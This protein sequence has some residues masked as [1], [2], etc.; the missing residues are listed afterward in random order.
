MIDREKKFGEGLLQ[1]SEG[2]A[3]QIIQESLEEGKNIEIPSQEIT[4]RG[5]QVD[6]VKEDD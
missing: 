5:W 2:L 4:V 3:A 6:Q 1:V